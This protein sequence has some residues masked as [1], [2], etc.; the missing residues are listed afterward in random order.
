[1]HTAV[2]ETTLVCFYTHEL[3]VLYRSSIDTSQNL[4]Q[5]VIK[6][7]TFYFA[8][9]LPNARNNFIGHALTVLFVILA[10]L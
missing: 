10:V 9:F 3:R 4:S 5:G 8:L 7:V 2:P 6:L 1:M